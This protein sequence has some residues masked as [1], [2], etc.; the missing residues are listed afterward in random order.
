MNGSEAFRM[1]D[2]A[3]IGCGPVGITL[4]G[5]LGREGVRV[6]VFDKAREVFAQPRAVGFDHDAMRL[7]QRIGVAEA[8]GP[9]VT[10]FR[11]TVFRGVDGQVIQQVR[12]IDPPYPYTWP[13]NF[14]CDQPGVETV[15]RSAVAAMPSVRMGLGLELQAMRPQ[16]G[17]VGLA[18][19]DD[20]GQ[21]V[22]GH[23]RWVVGCDG[24]SS[25]VR[26]LAGLPLHSYDYDEPWIVVDLKVDEAALVRLPVTNVQYCEPER[27]CTYIV[28]P[29]NHRRWEF[30]RLPGEPAEGVLEPE[31]LWAL[32]A[33]WLQPG[34]AQ[35]W[36][37]AAYR[38]HALIARDWRS[39]RVLLA[40]DSAHQT[41][42]FMGQGMCQ[43][44][45]D[46]GNLAWK[47]AAVLRGE[48]HE[49]LLDSYAAERRPH[50]EATT[51]MA[52]QLGQLLSERDP[53][54]A[55]DRDA[56]LR[57]E[58]GGGPLT[59]V[60]QALIPPLRQGLI[61][62]GAPRA[63][64]VLPQP[65]VQDGTRELLLHDLLGARWQL[66]LLP[67]VAAQVAPA[68]AAH[69]VA[70]IV[71]GERRAGLPTGVRAV[72]ETGTLL[73]NWLTEAGV[74]GALVR[75]DHYVY[76]GFADAA[77]ALDLLR[78]RARALQPPNP[79]RP[80]HR[81]PEGDLIHATAIRT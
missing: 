47:L 25:T 43:G 9:H 65:R 69:G 67:E 57:A 11:N 44:L 19:V 28:C 23:A 52:R 62:S 31:R 37:A 68:A 60:R 26:R 40:G 49:A 3:V 53:G 72:S 27:P 80:G 35:L 8:L 74:R 1:L 48:A 59:L 21:A 77:Q 24:A 13:P 12:R 4:A 63:G 6:G 54:R 79:G 58:A 15:L 30:M 39:G 56:R 33:R 5:L 22:E 38:F 78:H 81:S 45:R 42:P 20:G 32:L 34:E 76:G 36:R 50:V 14:T 61:A 51:L 70:A 64:E 16:P 2:V 66:V 73:R 75:P 29:G 18:L 55:R 41:P 10:E 17:G 46:A 7:F 71:L